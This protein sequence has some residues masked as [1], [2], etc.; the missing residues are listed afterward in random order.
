MAEIVKG[1][2]MQAAAFTDCVCISFADGICSLPGPVNITAVEKKCRFW[3]KKKIIVY[4][5]HSVQHYHP[6][7]V[8]FFFLLGWGSDSNSHIS[9]E[10]WYTYMEN[11]TSIQPFLSFYK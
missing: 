6:K 8:A 3:H 2:V 7:Y 4:H 10:Y 9:E 5:V 1:N 11:I